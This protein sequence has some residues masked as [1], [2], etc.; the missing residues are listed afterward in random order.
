MV[1]HF[2]VESAK[3]RSSG[4][5]LYVQSPTY[6]RFNKRAY[7]KG[8]K[9]MPHLIAFGVATVLAILIFVFGEPWLAL[10]A[11]VGPVLAWVL[12]L[13]GV[14]ASGILTTISGGGSFP[15]VAGIGF[16]VTIVLAVSSFFM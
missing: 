11:F 6:A 12:S 14:T 10:V 3:H 15:M 5:I 13:L 8:F 2:G 4:L 9:E 16:I 7:Y 1:M